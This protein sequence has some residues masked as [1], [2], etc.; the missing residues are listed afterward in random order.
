MQPIQWTDAKTKLLW[1]YYASTPAF[2]S[3]YFSNHTGGFILREA[4]KH[5][6]LQGAILDFGCGPGYLIGHLLQRDEP[7]RVHGLDFSARSV[8][9]TRE[10]HQGNPRFG[11]ATLADSLPSPLPEA[12]M[13]LVFSVEVIEHLTDAQLAGMLQEC[14]RVLK[15][16]GHLVLTTPHDEDLEGNTVLCPECGTLF[17]R[18][19]HLRAWTAAPLREWLE[20]SGFTPLQLRACKF[21]SAREEYS[22]R[23]KAALRALLGRR[24]EP[25]RPSLLAIARKP[26]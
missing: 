24:A 11:G 17:H 2:R 13:D 21:R 6:S 12:S 3:Q 10:Q 4:A 23:V 22:S 19:Q 16:G 14:R 7:T 26:L 15:P 18:W 8:A 5:L 25:Y 20:R 9:E 1:D